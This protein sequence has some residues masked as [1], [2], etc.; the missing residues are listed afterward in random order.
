MQVKS[1]Y[2]APHPLMLLQIPALKDT[3]KVSMTSQLFLLP[4]IILL[5]HSF[6]VILGYTVIQSGKQTGYN[7]SV[8]LLEVQSSYVL[9]NTIGYYL[10]HF[11]NA[12]LTRATHNLLKSLRF[13]HILF[14]VHIQILYLLI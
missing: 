10:T 11:S 3:A 5:R 7:A 13:I 14:V 12:N 6:T 1:L 2:H 9:T 8:H 4:T